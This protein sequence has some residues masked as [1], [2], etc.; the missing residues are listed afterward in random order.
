M[1][2]T[3]D[4]AAARFISD[5]IAVM[6]LGQI[7]ELAPRDAFFA[8][9]AHPYS[10]ALLSA[11]ATAPGDPGTEP[12]ETV[13]LEGELP[14]PTAPPSACRF[15]ARCPFAVERCTT[16][17]PQLRQLPSGRAVRCHFPLAGSLLQAPDPG[18]TTSAAAPG[19]T[20]GKGAP[21]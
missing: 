6:Y 14:D 2:V 3:H 21:R 8:R 17:A 16:D 15:S 5:R 18:V 7:V 4:L 20:A 19:G 1:F 9:P 10:A 12:A 13:M 11:V